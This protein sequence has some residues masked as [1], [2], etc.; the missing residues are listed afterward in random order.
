MNS[1]FVLTAGI[2]VNER[3]FQNGVFLLLGWQRNR[4]KYIRTSTLNRLHYS[5]GRLVNDLMIV[6]FDFDSDPLLVFLSFIG[7]S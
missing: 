4:T 2:L 3:R 1:H 7:L 5:F 6:S